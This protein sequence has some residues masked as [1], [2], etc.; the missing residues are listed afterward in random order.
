MASDGAL[1]TAEFE[2]GRL[3]LAVFEAEQQNR[4]D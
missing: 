3:E 4:S 1:L 2:D